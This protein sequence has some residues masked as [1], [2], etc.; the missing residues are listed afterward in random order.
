MNRPD[1]THRYDRNFNTLSEQDQKILAESTVTIIGLGG[2]GG[3]VC[4]LLARI[5]VGHLIVAD[6]DQFDASNLNRQLLST[7][8]LIG[9]SKAAAAADRIRQINSEVTVTCIDRYLDRTTM[10]EQ[11]KASHA[12]MDCLDTIQARFQLQ[13]AAN[14]TGI[15]IVSGAIAG[16][17]GQ[18]TTIFP[19]DPGYELI[20]GRPDSS[21]NRGVETRTGNLGYCALCIASIQSSECVKLLTG[22]GLP[23]RNKL[24]IT[25]MMQNSF[26]VIALA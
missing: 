3:G 25:D 21:E 10:A 14:E 18:V 6:G 20:Y 9:T 5:G 23:L 13:D 8:A 2:L 16:M 4:E 17:A 12:A 22:K 24:L 19:G 26:E 7:E 11:I 1:L 15:P